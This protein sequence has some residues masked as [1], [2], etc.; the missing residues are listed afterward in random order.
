MSKFDDDDSEFWDVPALEDRTWRHPSEVAAG[1]AAQATPSLPEAPATPTRTRPHLVGAVVAAAMCTTG[2][3]FGGLLEPGA[4]LQTQSG[5][6][7]ADSSV[8]ATS[9]TTQTTD[10]GLPT[11]G[12]FSSPGPDGQFVARHLIVDN[13]I[14]TSASAIDNQPNLTFRQPLTDTVGSS[15]PLDIAV[16]VVRVST[17]Y[18]LAILEIPDQ[19]TPDQIWTA[20]SEVDLE[21]GDS[22]SIDD[23][24]NNPIL[25]RISSTNVAT[26]L[27]TGVDLVEV[28]QTSIP[29]SD[30]SAGSAAIDG[31]G[32]LV[33]MGTNATTSEAVIVPINQISIE[34]ALVTA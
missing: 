6:I 4:M 3:V 2:L 11:S 34:L 18:D 15:E 28:T 16:D 21:V 7:A 22:V 23:C 1:L 9:I 8:P 13:F 31:N 30:C 26:T 17:R 14:I 32:N 33:G 19:V 12:L 20:T 24:S 27:P 5:Q 10:I 25:G 29:V